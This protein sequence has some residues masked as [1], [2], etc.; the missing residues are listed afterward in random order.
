[1][2]RLI[3]LLQVRRGDFVA[4]GQEGPGAPL[5]QAE[6]QGEEEDEGPS[7]GQLRQQLEQ[8][9]LEQVGRRLI[10]N[11]HLPAAAA[12]GAAAGPGDAAEQHL[13]L[14]HQGQVAAAAAQQPLE[15]P[16]GE[17]PAP[18]DLDDLPATPSAKQPP[19]VPVVLEADSPR[20]AAYRGPCQQPPAPG[21]M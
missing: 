18:A 14:Q 6:G 9:F 19:K 1:M 4:E 16:A 13:P 10:A 17:A 7:Q 8:Q 15:A 20:I 11:L 3:S 5:G 21:G 2:K 12:P